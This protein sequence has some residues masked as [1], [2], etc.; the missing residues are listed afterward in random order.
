M[1]NRDTWKCSKYEPAGD[2]WR[3]S[4]NSNEVLAGSRL[5]T[6]LV[7]AAYVAAIR[8]HAT[9]RLMDLGCGKAPLY[10]VYRD[11]STEVTCVDWPG[12]AHGVSHVDRFVDLNG[13]MPFESGSFD[14]IICT[15]VIEHIWRHDVLWPEIARVLAPGGKAIIGTPFMYWL[16]EEPHDYFRWTP[17]ALRAGATACGLETIEL[18]RIGGAI[19]VVA[20]ILCKITGSRLGGTIPAVL[21]ALARSRAVRRRSGKW[22]GFALAH[23]TVVMKS[24]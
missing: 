3:A 20:D 12:S 11:H 16:H 4:R 2:S 19:D 21:Q 18:H 10:G 15:D 13:P 6:D 5:I 8:K 24:R 1:Q 7:C 9:G 17:H 23:L 14:T 22:P